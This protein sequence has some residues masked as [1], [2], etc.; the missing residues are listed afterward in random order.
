[1]SLPAHLRKSGPGTAGR[2]EARNAQICALAANGETYAAIGR[3]FQLSGEQVRLIVGRA[4][5]KSERDA[6]TR[7]KW[8]G[9][10]T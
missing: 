2:N 8:A 3:K 9:V 10:F 1:M 6:R 5:Q 4:K 7:A